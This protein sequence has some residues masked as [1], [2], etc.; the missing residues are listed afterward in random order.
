M[1]Q[2]SDRH[3]EPG[4]IRFGRENLSRRKQLWI[5]IRAV[6]HD[7][8][9]I[10]ID[11]PDLSH[12]AEK[13]EEQLVG[14]TLVRIGR[15]ENFNGDH[16]RRVIQGWIV[17]RLNKLQTQPDASINSHNAIRIA[18]QSA[19]NVADID[20]A[21]EARMSL[22]PIEEVLA[23]PRQCLR[24]LGTSHAHGPLH[25]LAVDQFQYD[26]IRSFRLKAQKLFDGHWRCGGNGHV[27][28]PSVLGYR[29]ATSF[30][31]VGNAPRVDRRNR[32]PRRSTRGA[33]PA[34]LNE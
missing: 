25:N 11:H 5:G 14:D 4:Q 23:D 24:M 3:T 9:Q 8:L 12:S 16:W 28:L 2:L 27:K 30:N 21:H 29:N 22:Q 32:I 6:D 17:G 7:R 10:G 26:S 20:A 13:V 19:T 33:L 31:R 15:R 1:K 34:R 18:L